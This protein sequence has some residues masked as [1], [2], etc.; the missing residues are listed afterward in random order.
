MKSE[1][2]EKLLAALPSV[3]DHH[4]PTSKLYTLLKQVARRE[5]EYLFSGHDTKVRGF[6]PFGR[7]IFPY[8]SMGAIDSLNLFDIDELIIFSFYWANRNRYHRVLDVGANIGLHSI[9]LSRCGY[10]VRSYE[11]DPDTFKVLKRNLKLN[12]CKAVTPFNA[13]VSNKVGQLEF[14]RVLSNLTGSHIAGSKANPYGKLE[15]FPVKVEAIEPIIKW[16]DLIKLDAEGHEKEIILA[17]KKEHWR[18]T[19]AMIEVENANNARI[20]Y[21]H[22]KKLGLNMFSQKL[23]W[24]NVRSVKDMPVSYKEG[25]LFV[26]F[27]R[28]MPWG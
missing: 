13:A 6:N 23:N 16:A 27:K 7:L 19:D 18:G 2:L 14:V 17:T 11:P 9:L 8:H 25:S 5:V 24:Q 15:R 28:E 26:S 1:M 12:H 4:A 21:K 20:L 3:R 10:K 22:F